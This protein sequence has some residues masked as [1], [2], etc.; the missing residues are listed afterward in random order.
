MTKSKRTADIFQEGLL[1]KT[2]EQ[3][4]ANS[5]QK[6]A[7]KNDEQIVTKRVIVRDERETLI[8]KRG[9][10]CIP[11]TVW[12]ILRKRIGSFFQMANSEVVMFELKYPPMCLRVSYQIPNPN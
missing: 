9:Q 7:K 2:Q 11:K 8:P 5:R 10:L 6:S 1:L 12:K 4:G 3:H